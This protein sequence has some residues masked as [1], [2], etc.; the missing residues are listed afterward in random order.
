MGLPIQTLPTQ[1]ELDGLTFGAFDEFGC[2]W[3]ARHVEGWLGRPKPRTARTPRPQ[4]SGSYRAAAFGGERTI[5][6]TGATRC[7]DYVTRLEAVERLEGL[8][9]D[10]TRLYPFTVTDLRGISRTADVELDDDIKVRLVGPARWFDWTV[11]VAAPDPHRY[12]AVWQQPRSGMLADGG[13]GLD[14]GASGLNFAPDGLDFGSPGS[15]LASQV[16][17]FGNARTYPIFAIKGPAEQP[18]VTDLATGE[19]IDF[20]GSLYEGDVLT[21]NCGEFPARG[22]P[23]RSAFL[24]TY[25]DQRVLL[26]VPS[27]W[28][29][30]GP[31]EVRNFQLSGNGLSAAELTVYLRSAWL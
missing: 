15:G 1:Y 29:S 9:G 12:D 16:A 27:L 7:P 4:A 3:I 10:L 13:P 24:N 23:A 6:L 31:G 30:V 21:I 18:R 2:W 28:P 19:H 5:T 26:S 8:A 17:N 22:F 14:F 20:G 11:V 25:S